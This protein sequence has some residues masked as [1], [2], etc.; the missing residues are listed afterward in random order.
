MEV[1]MEIDIDEQ[2]KRAH[3]ITP[4]GVTAGAHMNDKTN[5]THDTKKIH[6]DG[7]PLQTLKPEDMK[8]IQED[9]VM[10]SEIKE[11]LQTYKKKSELIQEREKPLERTHKED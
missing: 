7:T 6:N 1:N 10:D 3:T 5:T 11:D 2:K 8:T 4:L 9:T